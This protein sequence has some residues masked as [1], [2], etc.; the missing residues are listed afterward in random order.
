MRRRSFSGG[1]GDSGWGKTCSDESRRFEWDLLWPEMDGTCLE[2]GG[3]SVALVVKWANGVLRTCAEDG[4]TLRRNLSLKLAVMSEASQRR[5]LG[6]EDRKLV[7]DFGVGRIGDG[8]LGG[9]SWLVVEGNVVGVAELTGFWG[10]QM[11]KSTVELTGT[12]NGA[13]RFCSESWRWQRKLC[14]G[15]RT[16]RWQDNGG[17]QL[18]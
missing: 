7:S 8:D 6:E 5:G 14:A 18:G 11:L 9:T 3:S 2:F 1:C 13:G 15:L 17:Q 16:W 12:A 10:L 4:L